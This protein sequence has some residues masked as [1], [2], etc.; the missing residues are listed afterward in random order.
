MSYMYSLV[1][2]SQGKVFTS[3]FL[4]VKMDDGL[5]QRWV[6]G[7]GGRGRGGIFCSH[8]LLRFFCFVQTLCVATRLY[9]GKKKKGL[10]NLHKKE[11][12]A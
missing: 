11:T 8:N 10:E 12:Y 6:P 1:A 7:D 5:M 4:L 9:G 2:W 3:E